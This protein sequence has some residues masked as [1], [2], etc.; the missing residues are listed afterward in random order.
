[1]RSQILVSLLLLSFPNIVHCSDFRDTRFPHTYFESYLMAHAL[2]PNLDTK[3]WGKSPPKMSE[4][5]STGA[6]PKDSPC[7]AKSTLWDSDL[8]GGSR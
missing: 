4:L 5:L 6:S 8:A 1:M 2:S 3:D 7:Q